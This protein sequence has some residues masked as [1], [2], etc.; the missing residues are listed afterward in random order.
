MGRLAYVHC[1]TTTG[2]RN[3][4]RKLVSRER[5]ADFRFIRSNLVESRTYLERFCKSLPNF[6]FLPMSFDFFFG[7]NSGSHS[8]RGLCMT[9]ST[10]S[11]RPTGDKETNTVWLCWISLYTET[12]WLVGQED[13]KRTG[14]KTIGN[15]CGWCTS[16]CMWNFTNR[17]SSSQF[18]FSI[19]RQKPKKK[20]KTIL[21]R[22]FSFQST[23]AHPHLNLMRL[24]NFLQL[25]IS[26]GFSPK[27]VI[28]GKPPRMRQSSSLDAGRI[29]KNQDKV[30]HQEDWQSVPCD[31][32]ESRL[33]VIQITDVYTLEHLASVKTLIEETRAKSK[34][35]KVIS[36]MTGDF[37]APYL[38]SSVDRGFG[39]MNALA[40]IPIDYICWGNH[41]V[42]RG[43]TVETSLGNLCHIKEKNLTLKQNLSG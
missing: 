12:P 18:D 17:Y 23:L 35:A 38:L 36:I 4:T 37:L 41:E 32:Q 14:W 5:N 22:I 40:K 11:Y 27:P 24:L 31:P 30:N 43:V 29:S 7:R 33:T 34:G 21:F 42:R 16:K 9:W 13:G 39:M 10:Y 6:H 2:K 15:L 8:V 20:Q 25:T 3:L 1:R 28:W 26:L 19:E